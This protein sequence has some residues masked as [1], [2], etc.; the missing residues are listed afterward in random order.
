MPRA[1]KQ[2]PEATP[3]AI[4]EPEYDGQYLTDNEEDLEPKGKK[5]SPAPKRKYR[6]RT[7]KG[8]TPKGKGNQPAKA[9]KGKKGPKSKKAPKL[10]KQTNIPQ[11]ENQYQSNVLNSATKM[12]QMLN[13]NQAR[14][15]AVTS[16]DEDEDNKNTLGIDSQIPTM[17]PMNSTLDFSKVHFVPKGVLNAVKS[18]K[19]KKGLKGL[20]GKK[21]TKRVKLPKAL[22]DKIKEAQ[23]AAKQDKYSTIIPGYKLG[24]CPK[25]GKVHMLPGKVADK[26]SGYES[27]NENDMPM[28]QMPQ[29]KEHHRKTGLVYTSS[30]VNGKTTDIG[31]YIIDNSNNNAVV[32]GLIQDGKRTEMRIPRK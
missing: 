6:K 15:N 21:F 31:H 18:A 28:P 8:N 26:V 20:K 19:A 32:K 30:T 5:Q 14:L 17:R 10:Q 23:Q 27:D 11:Q 4:P 13:L 22:M 29:T 3:E 12:K 2:E 16:N 9:K 1:K 7:P 25:C 24:K